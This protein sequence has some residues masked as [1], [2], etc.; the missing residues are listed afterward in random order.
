MECLKYQLS[1][2][3][4]TNNMQQEMLKKQI[5]KFK[6]KICE[7]IYTTQFLTTVITKLPENYFHY[8]IRCD[9]VWTENFQ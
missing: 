6:R 3:I 4:K 8:C 7:M 9:S 5:M 2:L 1:S